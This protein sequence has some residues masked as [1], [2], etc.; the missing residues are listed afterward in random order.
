MF[1]PSSFAV[2]SKGL[3]LKLNKLV[4]GFCSEYDQ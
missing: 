4:V 1:T 3:E 2:Y